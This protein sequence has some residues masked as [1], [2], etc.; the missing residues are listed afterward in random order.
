[1]LRNIA[2]FACG[3]GLISAA[4]A[5]AQE[6]EQVIIYKWKAGYLTHYAKLPPRGIAGV[7]KLDKDGQIIQEEVDDDMS[8]MRPMRPPVQRPSSNNTAQSNSK[9]NNADAQDKALPEGAI[10]RDERCKQAQNDIEVLRSVPADKPVN[11]EDSEGNLVPMTDEQKAAR[12]AQ[13]QELVD[14]LCQ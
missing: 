14:R 9:D 2:L 3:I 12:M 6:S 11:V 5:Q 13:A 8:A 10:S 4:V 1:M 7:V